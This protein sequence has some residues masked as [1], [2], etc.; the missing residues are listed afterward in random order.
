MLAVQN[1]GE[2]ARFCAGVLQRPSLID[3]PRFITNSARVANRAALHE[4]VGEVLGGLRLAAVGERLDQARIAHGELSS[5]LDIVKN[6]ALIS[7]DR[8][9]D[10]DTPNGTVRAL[11]PPADIAGIE[12]RMLPVPALGEHSE[13]ILAELGYRTEEIAALRDDRVIS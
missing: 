4:V 7:R 8:W 2:W 13:S 10:V 1:N 12:P 5:I 9:R 6:P 3:D 11:L